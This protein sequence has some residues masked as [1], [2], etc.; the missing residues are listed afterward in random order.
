MAEKAGVSVQVT[1]EVGI[2]VCLVS[3][4]ALSK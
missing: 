2:P 1:V 3:P 4:I